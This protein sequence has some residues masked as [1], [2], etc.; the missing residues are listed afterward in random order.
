MSCRDTEEIT[1]GGSEHEEGGRKP[2][3]QPGG[4]PTIKDHPVEDKS[5]KETE[6]ESTERKNGKKS[7]E[8]GRSGGRKACRGSGGTHCHQAGRVAQPLQS[9]GPHQ[10]RYLS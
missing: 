9:E 8:A 1:R 5:A 6:K 4:S 7:R 2:G 3:G 10:L